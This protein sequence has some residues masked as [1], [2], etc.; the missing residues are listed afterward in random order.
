MDSNNQQVNPDSSSKD[1]NNN[2]VIVEQVNHSDYIY[3]K[4]VNWGK[5]GQVNCEYIC[6]EHGCCGSCK[7][8]S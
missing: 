2:N 5:I 3:G 6:L 8:A 1:D 4:N 7:M